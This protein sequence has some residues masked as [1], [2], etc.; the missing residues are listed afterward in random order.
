MSDPD[1]LDLARQKYDQ[2]MRAVRDARRE[3]QRLLDKAEALEQQADYLMFEADP[4]LRAPYT[5]EQK[6]ACATARAPHEASLIDD[7]RVL[8]LNRFKAGRVRRKILWTENLGGG[9]TGWGI[10]SVHYEGT[11]PSDYVI[12]AYCDEDVREATRHRLGLADDDIVPPESYAE[13][14]EIGRAEFVALVE[15]LKE[16]W[17]ELR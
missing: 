4:S 17:E 9:A 15:R 7:V 2:A 3:A 14:C 1:P 6:E 11:K 10:A 13:V 16:E 12:C 8:L 5:D